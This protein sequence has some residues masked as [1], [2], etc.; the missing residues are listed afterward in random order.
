MEFK[1]TIDETQEAPGTPEKIRQFLYRNLRGLHAVTILAATDGARRPKQINRISLSNKGGEM[2]E[3]EIEDIC[4]AI[5]RVIAQQDLEREETDPPIDFK[6]MAEVKDKNGGRHRPTVDYRYIA[7]GGEDDFT[8]YEEDP[9]LAIIREQR[10][11]IAMLQYHL[12]EAHTLTRE[13]ANN[14]NQAI[15]PLMDALGWMGH[16]Y[17]AGLQNQQAA[18]SLIYDIKKS[19]AEERGKTER[20]NKWIDFLKKPAST[21]A[22]QFMTWAAQ[23]ASG[24]GPS[25]P[26]PPEPGAEPSSAEPNIED[27]MTEEQKE[28]PVATFASAMAS[29]FTSDQWFQLNEV[30]SRKEMRVFRAVLEATTDR[31]CVEAY[32]A[33]SAIP[34]LKLMQLHGLMNEEQQ[35]FFAQFQ[36]LIAAVKARWDHGDE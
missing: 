5:M 7:E 10:E 4:D 33:F 21:L 32:E 24:K 15:K 18:M 6:I 30:L 27:G 11:Y 22:G 28:N 12:N 35:G 17:A 23:K 16:F 36:E 2:P 26:P 19:E 9:R 31:E 29:V 25:V 13:I 1:I 8:N 14:N 34:A 3:E 20:T